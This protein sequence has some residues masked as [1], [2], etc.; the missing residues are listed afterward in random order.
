MPE[1]DGCNYPGTLDFDYNNDTNTLEILTIKVTKKIGEEKY[2][3]F[4]QPSSV[5]ID[6]LRIRIEFLKS[7][8]VHYNDLNPNEYF[9]AFLE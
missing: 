6:E 3:F 4:S 9:F 7:V 2:D 8:V 1:K 5:P